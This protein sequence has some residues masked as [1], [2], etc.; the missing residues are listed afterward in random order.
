MNENNPEIIQKPTGNDTDEWRIATITHSAIAGVSLAATV[1]LAS[2]QPLSTLL[3]VASI[4]FAMALPSAVSSVVLL[5]Y[6]QARNQSQ[7]NKA[8][9]KHPFWSG[10]SSFLALVAQIACFGG[11]LMLFWNINWIA[12][13]AFLA[14]SLIAVIALVTLSRK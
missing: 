9:K 8:I 11:V 3:M 1:E 6:F 13:V 14:T 5:Q 2:T 7:Y 4:F 10:V 12:G